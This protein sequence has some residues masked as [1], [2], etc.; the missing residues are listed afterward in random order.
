M[1]TRYPLSDLL[2]IRLPLALLLALPLLA[3]TLLPS[4]RLLSLAILAAI[5]VIVANG[6]HVI[7]SHTGQLSLA[8]TAVW[9]V[10]AYT[11]AL[12]TVHWDWPTEAILPVAG[13]CAAL[14]AVAIGIPAFRT[15]GFSFAIM[16]FAFAELMLLVANN[17]TDL[18][19][20][21]LGITIPVARHSIALV[22]FDNFDLLNSFYYMTLA[23]AYLSLVA[24]WLIRQSFL[25]RTFVA[26]RE[27]EQLA[28]SLGINVYLYKLTALAI[29]GFFAGIAGV[30]LVYRQQ[31][32][33][34]G[35]LSQFTAFFTIQFLLMI[36]IGGRFS[37]LGPAI[38]AVV[39]VFGPEL[40]NSAFGDVLSTTR[41]QIIFGLML[42]L[43][44][45]LSPNGMAGQA[46]LRYRVL[47]GMFR[48]YRG[49][50]QG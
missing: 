24:V 20:G 48:R 21:S 31:H 18:T 49:A 6:L 45:L 29:S 30:F 19:G 7:F 22:E 17:W 10:G 39:V 4:S 25:G 34:P 12:L 36:L 26:I 13:L 16:T 5:Y 14:A 43:G 47:A 46:Q 44:V 3:P 11:A 23:F 33:D 38:G 37:S 32:V 27:N 8:H 1:M 9:G 40:I 50:R 41:I 2:T 15:A 28:R 35:P 42:I